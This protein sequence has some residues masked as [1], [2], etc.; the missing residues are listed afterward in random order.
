MG[1]ALILLSGN[2]RG[3]KITSP[4]LPVKSEVVTESKMIRT[5]LVKKIMDIVEGYWADEFYAIEDELADEVTKL[6]EEAAET[7][8]KP[9]PR[10]SPNKPDPVAY[11]VNHPKEFS[12]LVAAV[13][14]TYL[15]ARGTHPM[16]SPNRIAPVP[17]PRTP[18]PPLSPR[19]SPTL[20]MSPLGEAV[21]RA[22]TPGRHTPTAI[23]P[24]SRSMTS[25]RDSP[26]E[27]SD[28][29]RKSA[30]PAVATSLDA[31]FPPVAQPVTF[32]PLI[33]LLIDA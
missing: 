30:P 4:L 9:A 32:P 29:A 7:R 12:E 22:T 20:P 27:I 2:R 3:G 21:A 6:V 17:P 24:L 8:K 18:T 5:G 1:D 33:P 13:Q 23:A 19:E 15:P 31:L 25:H 16:M 14:R 26:D 28:I 10:L 11:Y